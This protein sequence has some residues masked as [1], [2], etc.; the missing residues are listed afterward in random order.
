MPHHVDERREGYVEMSGEFVEKLRS[1]IAEEEVLFKIVKLVGWV[2][3][4]FIALAA[5][6]LIEKN[7]DIKAMQAT[8][9]QHSIQ[10]EKTLVLIQTVVDTNTRQQAMIDRNTERLQPR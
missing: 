6:V 1:H 4:L 7:N 5:W 3:T 10:I 9:N 8:L 2:G